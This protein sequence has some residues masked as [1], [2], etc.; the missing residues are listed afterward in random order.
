[1]SIRLITFDLDHTLWDPQKTLLDAEQQM[2]T[3]L[4]QQVPQLASLYS[5]QAL[6]DYR[7]KIAKSRPSLAWQ[8]SALRKRVLYLAL[9]QV[10]LDK[11][12]IGPLVEQAFAVFYQARS[13]LQL[14]AGV[15]TM[16]KQLAQK[17]SLIALTNGNADLKLVGIDAY[18]SAYFNA[19]MVGAAKP[20]A[21]MFEAALKAADVQEH[22]CIHV[23]DSIEMD[24]LAAQALGIGTVWA[25]FKQAVWPNQY[26][27]ADAVVSTIEELH[28]YLLKKVDE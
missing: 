16:L 8:V 2:Y 9:L 7:I 17:C 13:R 14:F 21:A 3:W 1:M 15:E 20:N 19:E 18:F 4:C 22:E 27:P 5:Q 6:V 23:G 25:N 24:V 10:G 26:R 28:Q 11:S 12:Q